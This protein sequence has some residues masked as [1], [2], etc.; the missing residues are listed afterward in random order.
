ME[1]P[2]IKNLEKI[3]TKI[4]TGEFSVDQTVY[5]SEKE[6]NTRCFAGWHRHLKGDLDQDI[7]KN[8][9]WGIARI[10][11]NLTESEANLFFHGRSCFD[12]QC[13]ALNALKEGRRLNLNPGSFRIYSLDYQDK[14]WHLITY[15]KKVQEELSKFLNINYRNPLVKGLKNFQTLTDCFLELEGDD[16]EELLDLVLTKKEIEFSNMSYSEKIN[17]AINLFNLNLAEAHLLFDP[18]STYNLKKE[19]IVALKYGRISTTPPAIISSG[20]NILL[21]TNY[22]KHLKDFF[23][24]FLTAEIKIQSK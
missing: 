24:P 6:D 12:L 4:S 3:L 8:K 10:D 1:K 13:W 14:D 15:E 7:V 5:V 18:V 23:G 2:N 9:T 20:K 11:N 16:D 21:K 19:T 17:L 22:E